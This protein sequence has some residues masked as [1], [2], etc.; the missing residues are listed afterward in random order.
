MNPLAVCFDGKTVIREGHR[1]WWNRK[2]S[3]ELVEIPI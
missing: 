1:S 2:A 3:G